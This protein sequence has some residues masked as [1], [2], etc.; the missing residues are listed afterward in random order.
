MTFLLE[1]DNP[2]MKVETFLWRDLLDETSCPHTYHE[3][4]LHEL[5]AYVKNHDCKNMVPLGSIPFTNLFFQLVHNIAQ[6]NPVEIPPTLR[7]DRFVGRTYKIVSAK[8]VPAS[9]QYFI[10]DASGFKTMSYMGDMKNFNREELIATH[11]YVVSDIMDVQAEYRV[12]F[13]REEVYAIEY[14]NG[15]PLCFP[16]RSTIMLANMK[17]AQAKDYPGSYTMDVMVTKDGTFITE[18]HPVLFSC[19]LYTTVL[20]TSFLNGYI[21]GLHYILRHN[22]PVTPT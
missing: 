15:N 13:V 3:C 9:G 19:G 1:I 21:D 2:E 8:D 17:Y 4:R 14:Y 16:D 5:P 11:Q 22:T 18:I 7:T 20:S 12:Y 6:M 10:K